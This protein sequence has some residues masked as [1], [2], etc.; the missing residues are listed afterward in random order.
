MSRPE[1]VK[2]V[3]KMISELH[4]CSDAQFEIIMNY[5][6][7]LEYTISLTEDDGK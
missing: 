6:K 5:I 2:R 7:E 4:W 1:D 3:L